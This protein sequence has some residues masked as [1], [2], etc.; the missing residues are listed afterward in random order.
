MKTATPYM[1]HWFQASFCFVCFGA[2]VEHHDCVSSELVG[3]L[4]VLKTGKVCTN[5]LAVMM[6]V[7]SFLL[8][9][10]FSHFERGFFFF[11]CMRKCNNQCWGSPC[12]YWDLLQ[13]CK[14]YR[15][16]TWCLPILVCVHLFLV[17]HSN[18]SCTLR[19]PNFLF[20]RGYLH[21]FLG[22]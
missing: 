2:S 18:K 15:C 9:T 4:S 3:I 20:S 21:P 17:N 19:A 10:W 7:F 5:Y 22:F 1:K 16:Q 12:E 6:T 8:S 11:L 14:C 13:H